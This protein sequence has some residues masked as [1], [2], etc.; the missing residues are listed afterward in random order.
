M[1][2]TSTS[3]AA[4]LL[5]L[6]V[7]GQPADYSPQIVGKAWTDGAGP[8]YSYV[9][10]S[11]KLGTYFGNGVSVDLSVWNKALS[12]AEVLSLSAEGDMSVRKPVDLTTLGTLYTDHC[13]HYWRMGADL[14][15]N[16]SSGASSGGSNDMTAYG[17]GTPPGASSRAEYPW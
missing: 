12:A 5:T 9:A 16:G 2:S 17:T 14:T 10:Q 7:N 3:S 6:Y 1:T 8:T 11:G 15:D 4:G 13:V